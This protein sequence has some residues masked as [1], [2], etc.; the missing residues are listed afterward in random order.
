M[1]TPTNTF[2]QR[3][4]G[5]GLIQ[6]KDHPGIILSLGYLVWAFIGVLYLV[7]YYSHFDVPILKLLEIS[8]I[9]VAGLQ[10]PH[11]STAFVGSLLLIT[12]IIVSTQWSE[13]YQNKHPEQL[14]KWYAVLI[15][16]FFIVP[17]KRI[18]LFR[19]SIFASLILYFAIFLELLIAHR[20][21]NIKQGDNEIYSIAQNEALLRP[22]CSQGT[23]DQWQILGSTTKFLIIYSAA[24]DTSLVLSIENIDQIQSTQKTQ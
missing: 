24:C 19:L 17:K 14:K 22:N 5:N 6:L 16:I 2:T 9:L 7:L 11:A 4:F 1:N 8:D 18:N 23:T 21:N 3:F 10:E 15:K 12:F 13:N 20:V